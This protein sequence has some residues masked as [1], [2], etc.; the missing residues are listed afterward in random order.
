MGVYPDGSPMWKMV[1]SGPDE[2]Q[3]KLIEKVGI[4]NDP[5]FGGDQITEFAK[6]LKEKK[7]KEKGKG[8]EKL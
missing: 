2:S 3:T 1:Y 4:P 6:L 8:K 7:E 5:I